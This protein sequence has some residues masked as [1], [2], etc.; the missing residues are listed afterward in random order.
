MRSA[1][2]DRSKSNQADKKNAHRIVRR[3]PRPCGSH[4][5]RM[6]ALALLWRARLR[7]VAESTDYRSL[8]SI[9]AIFQGYG[10]TLCVGGPQ[11]DSPIIRGRKAGCWAAEASSLTEPAV[12]QPLTR[13]SRLEVLTAARAD[14][15]R[16]RTTRQTL[17]GIELVRTAFV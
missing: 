2:A 5:H 11:V 8:N 6:P 1:T 9:W 4:A 13:V 12:W 14:V 10:A 16:R 7:L 3:V 15:L 17:D